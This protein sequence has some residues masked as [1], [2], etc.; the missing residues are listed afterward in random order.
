L[1][2]DV[3]PDTVMEGLKDFHPQ[4]SLY[5]EEDAKLRAAFGE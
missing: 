1:V 2:I 3:I 4:T 5:E